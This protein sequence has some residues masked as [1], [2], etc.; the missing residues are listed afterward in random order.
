MEDKNKSLFR[1]ESLNRLNSPE[2]LNQYIHVTRPSVW[3]IFAAIVVLLGGLVVWVYNG[4]I[5]T[6][7]TVITEVS[8]GNVYA[9]ADSR[10]IDRIVEGCVAVVDGEYESYVTGVSNS[11]VRVP[12]SVSAEYLELTGRGEKA[13]VISIENLGIPDGIYKTELTIEDIRPLHYFL[14]L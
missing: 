12:E 6:Y 11:M 4:E 9:Y 3:M 13:Y 5:E 8:D 14:G 2:Q 7:L 1:Q 10:D